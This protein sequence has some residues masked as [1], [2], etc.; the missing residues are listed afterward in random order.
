MLDSPVSGSVSTL[1]EG[2]LS[3]MVGGDDEAFRR[4]E[5][6]LR[7]IG[8]VVTHVGGNGQAVTMKIATNLSLAVQMLAFSEGV[9]LAEHDGVDRRLAVEVMTSSAIA[10]P[11]L[12][13]RAPLVVEPTDEAW[14]AM[15]LMR[16]D[17]RLALATAADLGVAVPSAAVAEHVLTRAG[18][19]GYDERDIASIAEVLDRDEGPDER[20]VARGPERGSAAA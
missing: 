18:D 12:K 20:A 19:L 13:A 17:L 6:I 16:K 5:P 10:S 14:F 4:V 15:R 3:L 1:E 7:Q 2:R 11:M 8:P 9:L